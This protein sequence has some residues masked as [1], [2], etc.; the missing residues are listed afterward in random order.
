MDAREAA[1][2]QVDT[3]IQEKRD[4]YSLSPSD[5]AK[6]DDLQ[7]QETAAKQT[8][9]QEKQLRK[10][11]ESAYA[12]STYKN[13]DADPAVKDA[14]QKLNA[15]KKAA[16]KKLYSSKD[17]VANPCTPCMQKQINKVRDCA[18]PYWTTANIVMQDGTTKHYEGPTYPVCHQHTLKNYD[19]WDELIQKKQKTASEKD[20]ISVMSANE[21][22]LD[23]VQ[24][25]DSQVASLGA[26]QKTINK[27][28]E[29]E[30][31]QQ[32]LEFKNSDP[33]AYKRL[34]EDKGWTVRQD[35]IPSKKKGEAP[36]L[37]APRMYWKDPDDPDAEEMRGTELKEYVDDPKDPA[38]WKKVLGPLRDA[39]ADPEFKKKQVCDFN[40]RLATAMNVKPNG[41]KGRIE[42]YVT[43]EKA[44]TYVLDQSVNAPALVASDFGKS[45]KKFYAAHPK[46]S[47][48]P[49]TWPDAERA[50]Y[51]KE[52]MNNYAANRRLVDKAKRDK[53]ITKS[54]LSEDPGSLKW[55]ENAG[56]GNT[57]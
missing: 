11:I 41:Y 10:E 25:W 51:E 2:D 24:G 29:G 6:L 30:L 40:A 33:E 13:P 48:D 22:D 14:W 52:I 47:K 54:N 1:L 53:A 31:P 32:V 44:A 35:E 49:D 9:E 36:S 45:L 19:G 3:N 18:T 15:H 7:K 16:G 17:G 50:K 27:Q 23:T 46:V 8:L 43:S 4:T 37:S 5:A 34:F 56:C 38:R 26:M 28:G 21:G 42:D 20:I 39:G 55:P 57:P 12:N